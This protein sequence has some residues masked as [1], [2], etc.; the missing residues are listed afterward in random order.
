MILA[1]PPC[2]P[3][4][5]APRSLLSVE[6]VSPAYNYVKAAYPSKLNAAQ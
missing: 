4:S 5:R 2:P 6:N 3:P 1:L